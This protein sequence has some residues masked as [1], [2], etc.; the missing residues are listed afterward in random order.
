MGCNKTKHTCTQENYATCIHYELELPDFSTITD[1]CYNLEETTA[2]LYTLVGGIKDEIDLSSLADSCIEYIE[3]EDGKVVV[4]EVLKKHQEKICELE[5]KVGD[6]EN[7]HLCNL[8]V[9]GCNLEIGALV[10]QCG[11]QPQ[12]VGDLLQVLINQVTQ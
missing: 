6:L 4:Q 10:D 5:T 12:T 9:E 2:D 7:T 11:V 3:N 8:P 1:N